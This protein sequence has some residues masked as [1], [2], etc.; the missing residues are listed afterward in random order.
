MALNSQPAS[1]RLQSSLRMIREFRDGRV[2][3]AAEFGRLEKVLQDVAADVEKME[4][5]AGTAPVST[6][7]K[8]AGRNIVALKAVL[9]QDAAR[10]GARRHG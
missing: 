9:Q 6:Q 3:S 5:A 7:L 10:K 8:A 2:V 4:I 1:R